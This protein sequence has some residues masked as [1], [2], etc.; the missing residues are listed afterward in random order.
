MLS[1]ILLLLS[2]SCAVWAAE[3]RPLANMLIPMPDGKKIN[4]RQYRGKVMLIMIISTTCGDCIA[5]IEFVNRVQKDLGAQGFQAVAAAGDD[6][7]QFLVEPFVNRYKVSFPMGY[8]NMAEMIRLADIPKDKRPVAPIFM[9]VDKK[10]T[11]RFQYYGDHPFFKTPEGST[12]SIVQ[13]L[14]KEPAQ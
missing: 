14:M 2:L 6:N 10:G 9:F 13:G 5:S 4:L 11:V 7:A 1:R 3:P 8:L 12:R